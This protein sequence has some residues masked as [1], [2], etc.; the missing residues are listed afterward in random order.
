M[1]AKS[2]AGYFNGRGLTFDRSLYSAWLKC[3]HKVGNKRLYGIKLDLKD[4][5]SNVD[6]GEY[7]SN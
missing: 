6:I 3:V 5:F 1:S 7:N 2:V 4:A